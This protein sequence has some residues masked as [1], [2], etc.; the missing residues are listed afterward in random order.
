MLSSVVTECRGLRF[1][2]RHVRWMTRP[3][4]ANMN[5][6]PLW[7]QCVITII[8]NGRV[9]VINSIKSPWFTCA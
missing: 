6:L 5:I 3:R 2:I 1:S 8:M 9:T 7:A 4:V